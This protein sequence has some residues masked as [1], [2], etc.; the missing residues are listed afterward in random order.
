MSGVFAIRAGPGLTHQ[1]SKSTEMPGWADVGGCS[2]S[3]D[4]RY[5]SLNQI[6]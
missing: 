2:L 4:V 3:I 6:Q 1:N 5:T